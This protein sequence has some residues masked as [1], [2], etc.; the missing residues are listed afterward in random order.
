MTG[1]SALALRIVVIV[2]GL[3]ETL[4]VIAFSALMLQSTDPMGQ[5]ISQGQWPS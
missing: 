5:A 4:A 1:R 3:A 2:I